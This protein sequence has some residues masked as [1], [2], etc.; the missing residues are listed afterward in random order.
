MR[1]N[2]MKD[3]RTNIKGMGID[4]ALI[5]LDL[6]IKSHNINVTSFKGYPKEQRWYVGTN[7]GIFTLYGNNKV[8]DTVAFIEA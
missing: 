8:I 6:L 3:L 7:K 1:K 5:N 2:I 4:R